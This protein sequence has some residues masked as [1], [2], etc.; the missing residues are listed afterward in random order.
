MLGV[1]RDK[2]LIARMK[3]RR[4]VRGGDDKAGESGRYPMMKDNRIKVFRAAVE[5]LLE[6]LDAYVRVER[7]S[8]PGS[9]PEPLHSAAT[10]LV[11]RLGTADRLASG[12]FVGTATDSTKVTAMCSA[13][14]RLD[15]AYLTYRHQVDRGPTQEATASAALEAEI[16]EVR[17]SAD[18][19][20]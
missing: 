12:V 14:K 1:I 18:L 6:S 13:M 7:W 2:R 15:A 10:K 9:V 17:G 11:D 16:G 5:G 20:R 19:W 4:K 3:R 8:D